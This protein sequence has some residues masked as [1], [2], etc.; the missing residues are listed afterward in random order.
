[1]NNKLSDKEVEKI[2]SHMKKFAILKVIVIFAVIY[3]II[4]RFISLYGYAAGTTPEKLY[5]WFHIIYVISIIAYFIIKDEMK[6][7]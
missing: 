5:I 7:K 6:N 1:M 2:R 3:F 4:M